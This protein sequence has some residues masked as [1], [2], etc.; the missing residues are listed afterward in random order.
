M[1]IH[2]INVMMI[3]NPVL[4]QVKQNALPVKDQVSISVH[5][6]KAVNNV[7]QVN[8]MTLLNACL[9]QLSALLV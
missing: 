5:Q 1:I 8:I 7:Y 6:I 2:A 9:A 3:A 4:G